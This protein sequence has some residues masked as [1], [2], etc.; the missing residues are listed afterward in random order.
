MTNNQT[1]KIDSSL[2]ELD[3]LSTDKLLELLLDSQQNAVAAARNASQELEVAVSMSA[4]RLMYGDGRLVLAGA[5]ASGRLAIQDGAELWPTFGWPHERL[6]LCMAGGF[7]ALLSS[8]EGAE[9]DQDAAMSEVRDSEIGQH[10][11]VIAI[12]ASGRSRWTCAFLEQSREQGALTIGMANNADTPL[13]NIAECPIWLGTGAEV[14]AGSTRM[15]AGT[16]QKIALNGFS[17]ALMIRLNRTYG[18]LMVDMAAVNE[19]LNIRRIKLLQGVL[20]ELDEDQAQLALVEAGGWVKL[21]ALV[22]L[23][24]SV[25]VG[26]SRLQ[27]SDGSLRLAMAALKSSD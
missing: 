19:K 13:L 10:D 3:L 12:A 16:A 17:T 27:E 21:A 6:K 9:D 14:L 25:D 11:V 8:L 2:I 20:P 7:D 18:N 1:E 22:A 15:A 5:G 4:S 24:D 23:G 26:K